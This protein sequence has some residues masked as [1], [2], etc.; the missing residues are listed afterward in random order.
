MEEREDLLS[1]YCWTVSS[2]IVWYSTV[3]WVGFVLIVFSLHF[4][5]FVSR[6]RDGE[7]F[8]ISLLC[9]LDLDCWRSNSSSRFV[10]LFSRCF[11]IFRMAAGSS[12]K[13]ES[14]SSVL[15][16]EATSVR[17]VELPS[18]L[19]CLRPNLL[20]SVQHARFCLDTHKKKQM[21][22]EGREKKRIFSPLFCSVV[23]EF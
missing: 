11:G 4:C 8:S 16:A 6:F 12:I 20:F 5:L 1:V 3:F 2:A 10:F 17:L 7:D 14:R 22:S 18:L 19:A 15:M 13:K 23:K 9:V 21:H